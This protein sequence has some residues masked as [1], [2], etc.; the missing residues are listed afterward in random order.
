[1]GHLN[2]E[3]RLL[4][5]QQSRV[6]IDTG[7]SISHERNEIGE[8]LLEKQRPDKK[9]VIR[10]K[11]S[12]LNLFRDAVVIE[13]REENPG[14]LRIL[15]LSQGAAEDLRRRQKKEGSEQSTAQKTGGAGD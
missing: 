3:E 5:N 13:R 7:Q 9:T 10:K 11:L 6:I 4:Q 2:D 14:E 8:N 12:T 1:M 15:T